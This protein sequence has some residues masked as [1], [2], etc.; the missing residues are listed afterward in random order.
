MSESTAQPSRP[1]FNYGGQAVIEGVMMRGSHQVAIAVRNPEGAIVIRNEPLNA[2]V[3][4]GPLGRLPLLRG[5][6]LLWDF[7]LVK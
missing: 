2:A 5:L 7:W 4:N 6:I 1:K 3:Y